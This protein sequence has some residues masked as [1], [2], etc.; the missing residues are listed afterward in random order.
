MVFANR[1]SRKAQPVRESSGQRGAHGFIEIVSVRIDPKS[2]ICGLRALRVRDAMRR[3]SLRDG[4]NLDSLARELKIDE[5]TAEIL[6][7]ELV[8][9]NFVKV[10]P[11]QRGTDY[12]YRLTRAGGQFALATGARPIARKIAA[13]KLAELLKRVRTV[14]ANPD[15]INR[16]TKIYV[17]GS[18]PSGAS[19]V[20]DIDIAYAAERRYFGEEYGKHAEER[21]NLAEARSRSFSNMLDRLTWRDTEILLF[22][23][24][25]TGTISLHR[26]DELQRLGCAFKEVFP[27][28][29]SP[30]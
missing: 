8:A 22:L 14:N 12:S 24:A 7:K 4:F 13:R 30:S 3:F 2:E 10:S 20:S 27:R 16:I 28:T 26:A 11:E 21:R 5:A 29:L 19:H 15:Y 1:E 23:K 25:R 18:F 6:L 17:F 9:R